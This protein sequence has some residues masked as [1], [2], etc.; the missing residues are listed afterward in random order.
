MCV[1]VIVGTTIVPTTLT[2]PT[3]GTVPWSIVVRLFMCENRRNDLVCAIVLGN[4]GHVIVTV[5]KARRAV[6]VDNRL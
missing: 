1:S 5:G 3:S 2:V 4:T 6:R